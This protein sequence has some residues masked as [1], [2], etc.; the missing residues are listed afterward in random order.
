M[1]TYKEIWAEELR[2]LLK[3]CFEKE[4]IPARQSLTP[5]QEMQCR[6]LGGHLLNWL[7]NWGPQLI[8][9]RNV[10]AHMRPPEEM[11]E[12]KEPIIVFVMDEPGLVAAREIIRD[13]SG[14]LVYVRKTDFDFCMAINPDPGYVCHCVLESRFIEEG[15]QGVDHKALRERFS[16]DAATPIGVHYDCSTMGPL[17]ARGG[18]H[19]WAFTGDGP[20]LIEEAFESWVS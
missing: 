14:R 18:L 4:P 16:L 6:I 9:E 12:D 3:E 19:L 17:F 7:D 2:G 20:K 15:E 13:T 5:L 8:M 10:L 11:P 1:S